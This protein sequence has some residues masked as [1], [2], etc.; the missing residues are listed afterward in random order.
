MIPRDLLYLT[1][2]LLLA[3]AC[4]DTIPDREPTHVVLISVDTLRGDAIAD[5]KGRVLTPH[6]A[7]LAEEGVV[8]T[9]AF[10]HAS[11]TRPSHLALFS[12]R[13]PSQAGTVTNHDPV[14][15][16]VPLLTSWLGERNYHT[17]AAVSLN[18]VCGA[19]GKPES[20]LSRGFEE[21]IWPETTLQWGHRTSRHFDGMLDALPSQRNLFLFAHFADPHFPYRDVGGDPLPVRVLID[22]EEHAQ[23]SAR[24]PEQVPLQVDLPGDG[25]EV[26]LVSDHPFEV[27]S[28]H[29]T[30]KEQAI[31]VE[32]VEGGL[33]RMGESLTARVQPRRGR[34]TSA[35]LVVSCYDRPDLEESRRRYM[36]EVEL[37]DEHLGRL[38][39]QLRERGL[40][41]DA[42]IVVTSDHGEAL[43]EH[44]LLQHAAFIYDENIHVP[45]IIKPPKG[46]DAERSRLR[47]NA[48]RL[49]SH[50]DV[51]PTILDI[52]QL[53]P[54]PGQR[55]TSLIRERGELHFAEGRRPYA[56]QDQL[57]LRDH[58]YKLI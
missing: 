47:S 17:T 23:L 35:K 49:V 31:Q 29:G 55:G 36:Q 44:G 21:H 41:D 46:W 3:A 27:I 8:F 52:L 6:L 19:G 16:G 20:G 11:L 40:Y 53:E 18:A 45:L 51:V 48:R 38:F 39:D 42:L 32:F 5:E 14:D 34:P 13:L 43:G 15:K 25:V 56:R 37:V 4:A 58:H 9:Q 2:T 57:A 10:S 28:L 26:R 30:S 50:M 24:H 22:G 1:A 12:S 33:K 7:E 54:L